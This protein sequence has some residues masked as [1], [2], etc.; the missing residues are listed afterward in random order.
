M[1]R[2]FAVHKLNSR[3]FSKAERLANLFDRTWA[4]VREICGG[5]N[6]LDTVEMSRA[7][8]HMELASFYSKKAMASQPENQDMGE[9]ELAKDPFCG[10]A[11]ET[12][13]GYSMLR[14]FTTH[15]LELELK[16][17]TEP[18][19]TQTSPGRRNRL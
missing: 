16:R 13:A 9:E 1:H 14:D 6:R 4:M 10:D 17:R 18:A 11:N 3:G 8:E 12:A 5:E 15:D 7:N 2:A 19:T